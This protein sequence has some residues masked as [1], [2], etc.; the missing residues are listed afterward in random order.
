MA[1]FHA[2]LAKHRVQLTRLLTEILDDPYLAASLYFKGGTCAAMLGFLDRFSVDLDFDL[3]S[4]RDQAIVE[5]RLRLIF[6]RL[7]LTVKDKSQHVPQFFLK[8]SAPPGERN[9][10]KLDILPNETRANKYA[11]AYLVD[12]D[13]YAICQTRATL[14]ANKLVAPLDRFERNGSVAGRDI[15]D[16]HH[17]FLQG[18]AFDPAVIEERRGATVSAYLQTLLA[19]VEKQVTQ[20]VINQDLNVLLEPEKFQQIRKTLK[21]E[22][23]MFI[24]D[25][26]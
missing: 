3:A 10:L 14:F 8:Y 18:Y 12:V 6:T 13:R 9:T 21:T 25:A 22:V 4:D 23:M 26:M 5:E 20:T 15:Y 1:S 24:R 16:I 17:F 19:F 2:Q 7:N 11:Q